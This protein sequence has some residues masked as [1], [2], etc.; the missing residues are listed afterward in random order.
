MLWLPAL[1]TR[2]RVTRQPSL[3]F[4]LLRPGWYYRPGD[5]DTAMAVIGGQRMV[6][7]DNAGVV[8]DP[9]QSRRL[10]KGGAAQSGSVV[11]RLQRSGESRRPV[12][13]ALAGCSRGGRVPAALR[14]ML[15]DLSRSVCV[16]SNSQCVSVFKSGLGLPS[17]SPPCLLVGM[18]CP[19]PLHERFPRQPMTVPRVA[20]TAARE[21]AAPPGGARRG[22][23]VPRPWPAYGGRHNL[24]APRPLV[25]SGCGKGRR[26]LAG[27]KQT[28]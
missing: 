10:E 9:R 14:I 26:R 11:S 3:W 18:S 27:G 13:A 23:S 24:A 1:L 25:G 19:A 28:L 6:V 12:R 7:R 20:A 2:A 21:R 5:L 22:P 15:R 17:C 8:S 4:D 16:V